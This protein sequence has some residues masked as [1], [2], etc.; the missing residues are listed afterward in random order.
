MATAT[1][2]AP[3]ALRVDESVMLKME[4]AAGALPRV[5]EAASNAGFHVTDLSANEP[6]LETVFISLTGKDLRE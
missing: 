3:A 1:A 4:E 2:P 5:I 6:T